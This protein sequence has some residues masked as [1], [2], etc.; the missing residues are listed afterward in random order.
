M[1]TAVDLL[2]AAAAEPCFLL[3]KGTDFAVQPFNPPQADG[4][5]KREN[6]LNVIW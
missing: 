4:E 6:S 2:R 5:E 1:G 3:H